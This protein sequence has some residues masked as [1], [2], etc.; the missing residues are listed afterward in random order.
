[1]PA[2]ADAVEP[3]TAAEG[4]PGGLI[5]VDTE[6]WSFAARWGDR[7]AERLIPE[8]ATR[9]NGMGKKRSKLAVE[10]EGVTG[11][12][13]TAH[14]RVAPTSDTVRKVRRSAPRGYR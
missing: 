11:I 9:G 8:L 4:S 10:K 6:R 1:M 7:D 13:A 5:G 14:K 2:D 3:E 12:C